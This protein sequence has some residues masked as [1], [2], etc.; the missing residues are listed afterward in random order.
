[1]MVIEC[2]KCQTTLTFELKHLETGSEVDCE[3]CAARM[4]MKVIPEITFDPSQAPND[5]SLYRDKIPRDV[6]ASEKPMDRDLETPNDAQGQISKDSKGTIL[7]CIDGEATREV[8]KALLEALNYTVLDIPAG[9]SVMTEMNRS[10]PALALLDMGLSDIPGTELCQQ[11]KRSPDLS[12]TIV[13]LVSS[14]FEKNTKYR[15]E[16]PDLAGADDY[17]NRHEIQKGLLNKVE[18]QL[19][20]NKAAENEK[21]ET[22][23]QDSFETLAEAATTSGDQEEKDAETER[24]KRFAET[25]VSDIVMFNDRKVEEG[26]R[27]GNFYDVLADE[28]KE[29]KEVYQTKVAQAFWTLDYY[30]QALEKF[31]RESE[32]NR[33][34][35]ASDEHGAPSV[36]EQ[37]EALPEHAQPQAVDQA[38]KIDETSYLVKGARRLAKI[39]VSDI[40]IYNESK[41]EEGLKN[42][43]FYELLENEIL[44]GRQLYES[45]VDKSL[46]YAGIYEQAL[47]AFLQERAAGTDEQIS[48]NENPTQVFER[49]PT[50]EPKAKSEPENKSIEIPDDEIH[51]IVEKNAESLEEATQL[52]QDIVSDIMNTHIE[53][54]EEGLKNGTFEEVLGDELIIGRQQFE[55][56]APAYFDSDLF[57]NAIENAIENYI[58]SNTDRQNQT[59]NMAM[60]AAVDPIEETPETLEDDAWASADAPEA[61]ESEAPQDV[62]QEM[63]DQAQEMAQEPEVSLDSAWQSPEAVESEAPQDV[64]QEMEDQAQEMAQEPEVSLDSAWQS[65]EAVETEAP[66]DVFQEMEDQAQEMVQE[67][68]TSLED[69]A[70]QSPEAVESETPQDALQEM[71]S[72]AQEMVQEPKTSLEDSAWQSPEAV[73]SEAPQ[74]VFQEMESQAQEMAQEPEAVP[75]AAAQAPAVEPAADTD[76][77]ELKNAKR[78]AKIIVSDI[79]IYNEEKVEKGL[80]NDTFF[81]ILE[82]E[83]KEGR[84]LFESRVS[85][86][87]FETGLYENAI[88]DFINSRNGTPDQAI[89]DSEKATEVFEK[90]ES[91]EQPSKQAPEDQTTN[92][93]DPVE[94]SKAEKDAKRLAKIIVSD[95]MIYNEKKVEKGLQNGTFYEILEDEI[96][97]GRLLYES[98]VSPQ[99][100]EEKNYLKEALADFVSKRTA[101]LS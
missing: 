86:A 10:T 92:E 40:V 97:E 46:Y 96:K 47:E 20:K 72:Q 74:D 54:A 55:E 14:M 77:E 76:S 81:E 99:I 31:L 68:E 28:I 88:K 29:G 16:T 37:E 19:T 7:I 93:N 66:Q 63:E 100:L 13:I 89:P 34:K 61:V 5:G 91:P 64:F 33:A 48:D 56:K 25:I 23:T 12:Q 59:E 1:M 67:P 32:E 42:D 75:E 6:M 35:K 15:H 38:G 8:M 98:R 53:K 30:E 41:V 85:Q 26:L 24:A 27:D 62:F 39:I 79:V 95:I 4:K 90:I 44:E 71:E 58:A 50:P 3:R 43:N 69:S 73:E 45:R 84:L 57:E 9:S 83:I 78:L 70:W 87:L 52:A 36:F 21:F 18:Q 22:F 11:I 82:D 51:H 60:D 80:Q 17:I 94:E 101:S 65:P 49:V 2:P